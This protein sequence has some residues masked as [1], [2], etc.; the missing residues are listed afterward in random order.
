MEK[1]SKT[2]SE[3]YGLPDAD[4]AWLRAWAHR[5]L[6]KLRATLEQSKIETTSEEGF[7]QETIDA[8][9]IRSMRPMLVEFM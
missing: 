2:P 5:R 8:D 4:R 3:F 6:G 1:W 7:T 9:D